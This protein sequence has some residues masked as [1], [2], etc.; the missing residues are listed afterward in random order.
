MPSVHSPTKEGQA[1][2]IS[3]PESQ[4]QSGI[5]AFAQPLRDFFGRMW[6][7]DVRSLAVFRISLAL[8]ILVD[9]AI[10]GSD[11][12]AFYTDFGLLARGPYL[13]NF[14]DQW[15]V[16]IH[17]ISGTF[18]VQA[19]L[20]VLAAVFALFML[21]GYRTQLFTVL[22]W[23]ML[24]SLQSRNRMI[25]QGG[26]DLLRMFMFWAMFLPLGAVYSVDSALDTRP[27]PRKPANSSV[28]SPGSVALLAQVV[29]LYWF[30][31]AYKTGAEWRSEGSA[32]YYALSIEQMSTPIGRLMLHLP[33]VALRF[34]T[35]FVLAY[36]VVVPLLL[37]LAT[38]PF[39]AAAVLLIILL[40]LGMGTCIKL[41]PFPWVAAAG[42]SAFLPAWFWKVMSAEIERRRKF[43][44]DTPRHIRSFG[45]VRNS[46]GRNFR[47]IR[48]GDLGAVADAG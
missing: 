22:S 21:A 7:L 24:I 4:Q 10:R 38:G 29:M 11:L 15:F 35:F 32:M 27:Q 18:F 43:V 47:R 14:A 37:L 44:L 25:L 8:I 36:E 1:M 46:V 12:E 33:Q 42:I 48:S 26:D 5:A 16:S 34:M 45:R 13:Q 23:F 28:F 19:C 41:G 17:M 30:A 2:K 6:A 39:R 40:H 31:V 20:F 3:S 9:L